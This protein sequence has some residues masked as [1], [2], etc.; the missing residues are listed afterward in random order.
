MSETP[1]WL[2]PTNDAS[3]GAAGDANT[4]EMTSGVTPESTTAAG[5]TASAT[6][7]GAAADDNDLPGVILTMRLANMG[8]AIAL[9]ACSVRIN[10]HLGFI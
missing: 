4:F 5:S 6:T 10:T 1:G 8:V 3:A 9:V 7:S 2:S